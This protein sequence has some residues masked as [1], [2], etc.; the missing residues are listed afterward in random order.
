MRSTILIGTVAS[1]VVPK[2]LG[3]PI[4]IGIEQNE[5]KTEIIAAGGLAIGLALSA[6]ALLVLA[7]RALTPWRK[8]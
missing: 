1:F 4:F 2:G 8:A 6:D 5:F 3:Y 7:Q